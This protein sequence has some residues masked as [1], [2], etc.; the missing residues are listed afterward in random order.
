MTDAERM[1]AKRDAENAK[2]EANNLK[3]LEDIRFKRMQEQMDEEYTNSLQ[4]IKLD[5]VR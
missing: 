5:R 4:S 2:R 1:K 3:R